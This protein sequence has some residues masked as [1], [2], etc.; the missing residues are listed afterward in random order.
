MPPAEPTSNRWITFAQRQQRRLETRTLELTGHRLNELSVPRDVLKLDDADQAV[1]GAAPWHWADVSASMASGQTH[2][3][4]GPPGAGKTTLALTEVHRRCC[5]LEAALIAG[6]S[7]EL[8]AL[9]LFVP[10]SALTHLEAGP[11]QIVRSI[12]AI[13][14][15]FLAD[16][17]AEPDLGVAFAALADPASLFIAI[18]GL[19]TVSAA[20]RPALLQ[21]LA[22]LTGGGPTLL[23]IARQAGF[24]RPACPLR[25]WRLQP[26]TNRQR[27]AATHMLLDAEPDIRSTFNDR[28]RRSAAA[29]I[30]LLRSPAMLALATR[31][32][33]AGLPDD[34]FQSQAR[35]LNAL[36]GP[37][38]SE[39]Q[40]AL[41]FTLWR[42]NPG[43]D[44]WT[45]TEAN[46]EAESLQA[47]LAERGLLRPDA[48][49]LVFLH[50]ALA[51]A[52]AARGASRTM[53]GLK[54]LLSTPSAHGLLSLALAHDSSALPTLA[55][56]ASETE[57]T[58]LALAVA[59]LD[60]LPIEWT[61][62][63]DESATAM[64]A[65]LNALPDPEFEQLTTR[66]A[67]HGSPDLLMRLLGEA[68]PD[69][70]CRKVAERVIHRRQSPL[71]IDAA[72]DTLRRQ[73]ETRDDAPTGWLQRVERLAVDRLRKEDRW[74]AA[75]MRLLVEVQPR[76]GRGPSRVSQLRKI[77]SIARTALDQS[78]D[79]GVAAAHLLASVGR[80]DDLP[81]LQNAIMRHE[82]PTVQEAAAEAFAQ[83]ASHVHRR[84][85]F[86]RK[87]RSK[88]VTAAPTRA[89]DKPKK[90]R[91]RRRRRRKNA[92]G[93]TEA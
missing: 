56:E 33:I 29:T 59:R 20:Q 4:L 14:A 47:S 8:H 53:D 3:L 65:A 64:R 9:P 91:R 23:L 6:E 15:P 83:L 74:S 48:D 7:I 79:S 85:R 51:E 69:P 50:P 35:L 46:T 87:R 84:E 25:S 86:E 88:Q 66:I 58:A 31:R 55:S 11:E 19:D 32:A 41:A 28:M 76:L 62:D 73:S 21:A 18:D 81:W 38:L 2:A 72:F 5:A 63:L 10:A 42:Q 16:E 1:D 30:E 57:R 89:E 22:W 78:G 43:A 52:L 27:K 44:T 75:G 36:I 77:T 34:A 45:P 70:L 92:E 39:A 60:T 24:E 54:I 40:D 67:E 80:A 26:L 37:P 82:D 13:A 12:A 17:G 49:G 90:K 93:I 68:I 71:L 61:G